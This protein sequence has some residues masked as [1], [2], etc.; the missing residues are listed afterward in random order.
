MLTRFKRSAEG[1]GYMPSERLLIGLT[2]NVSFYNLDLSTG[3]K[4]AKSE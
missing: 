4:L 2:Q 3:Q 1:F